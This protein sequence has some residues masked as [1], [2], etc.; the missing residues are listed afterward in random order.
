[1][2]MKAMRWMMMVETTATITDMEAALAFMANVDM[3]MK[4]MTAVVHAS[5]PIHAYFK[6]LQSLPNTWLA[7]PEC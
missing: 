2:M 7:L 5:H 4:A 3:I 1:M 6:R